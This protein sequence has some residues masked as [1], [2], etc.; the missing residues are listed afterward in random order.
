MKV[1]LTRTCL[2]LI[3]LGIF[4][5]EFV[6]AKASSDDEHSLVAPDLFTANTPLG[7]YQGMTD[8][9]IFSSL[10]QQYKTVLEPM[11]SS[12]PEWRDINS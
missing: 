4:D 2:W 6:K 1:S 5:D 10:K 9:I 8:Q 11:G 12:L 3:S 7:F